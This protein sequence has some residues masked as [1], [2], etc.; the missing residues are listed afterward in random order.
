MHACADDSV[1]TAPAWPDDIFAILQR[2][3]VRQ[4][5]Y[6][7][8]AGHSQLIRR[9]LASSTMRGIPLTTE[10]EGVA[11]LLGAW[12][13][14]QRGVL[15]MQ[16]SGVGNCIN[17]LSLTQIFRFPFLTLVT[18]RGEWGE[19]NPWQVPMG[20]ATQAAFELAG[21]KVLRAS[22]AQEVREVVEAAASQAYNA[23]TPTAVL[24]S[25]RLI[26]AKVFVK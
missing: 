17:M 13:G 24:L 3:E 12:A 10:E 7:P 15:L 16:S 5:P 19:F 14:G 26:G 23:C 22:H 21:I 9:V 8:D 11:L 25:Q 20:S 2:F 18:M 1:D 4:V 6:V